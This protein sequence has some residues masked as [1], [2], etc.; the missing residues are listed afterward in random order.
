LVIACSLA[1]AAQ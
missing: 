1:V